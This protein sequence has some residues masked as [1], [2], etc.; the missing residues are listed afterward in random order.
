MNT[1]TPDGV[2]YPIRALP[3]RI[4]KY[5]VPPMLRGVNWWPFKKSSCQWNTRPSH[6]ELTRH[7]REPRG[8]GSIRGEG[9]LVRAGR[10]GAR[11][12]AAARGRGERR[13]GDRRRTARRKARIIMEAMRR[14][15]QEP[16]S[17]TCRN[18][19]RRQASAIGLTSGTPSH[20]GTSRGGA[21]SAC[22]TSAHAALAR[23]A[24]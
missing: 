9:W 19:T 5:V 8:S 7:T 12:D 24:E 21:Q 13:R 4:G 1:S 16:V 15:S 23:R 3:R 14:S 10:D 11:T 22:M 6:R 20:K 17:T 2:T 18:A